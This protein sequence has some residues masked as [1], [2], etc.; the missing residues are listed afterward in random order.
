MYLRRHPGEAGQHRNTTPRANSDDVGSPTILSLHSKY[1]PTYAVS[2]DPR[3]L[4]SATGLTS[5]YYQISEAK[6]YGR[7]L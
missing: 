1:L 7:E 5:D 2:T 6:S 3:A 4:S